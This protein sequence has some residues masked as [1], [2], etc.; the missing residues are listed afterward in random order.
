[1]IGLALLAAACTPV[2]QAESARPRP[3]GSPAPTRLTPAPNVPGNPENG[4]RVFIARGCGACHTLTGVPTAAGIV[5]PNLTNV[6]LRPTLAGDSIP[7]TPE[8]L[9]RWIL[10]PPALKPGTAMP[11]LGLTEQE[12]QDVTAFLY[13][14]PYN[15]GP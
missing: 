4:R 11:A 13:S 1:V 9:T 2:Q 14:Q 12:A 3:T 5:G 6:V 15:P 8:N 7:M 10:N